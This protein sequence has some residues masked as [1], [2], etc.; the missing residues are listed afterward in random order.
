MGDTEG[1]PFTLSTET[2]SPFQHR[3]L[4]IAIWR[5]C[6]GK[7]QGRSWHCPLGQTLGSLPAQNEESCSSHSS[8]HSQR[9]R[10]SN[11][12]RDQDQAPQAATY[13]T[14]HLPQPELTH[15]Q[16]YQHSPPLTPKPITY[17]HT[18]H[19]LPTNVPYPKSQT[20]YNL[21]QLPASG[22]HPLA[23]Y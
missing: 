20:T 7:T 17:P 23:L 21:Q 8:Q 10:G 19:S 2:A 4:K 15:C 11:G 12:N 13:T 9:Y 6:A 16:P 1:L 22:A 14:R 5:L 18:N 3:D